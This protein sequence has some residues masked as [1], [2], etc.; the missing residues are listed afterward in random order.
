MGETAWAELKP[1]CS[2]VAAEASADSMDG[3]EVGMP[4]RDVSS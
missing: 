4:H 1:N 2:V 3:C